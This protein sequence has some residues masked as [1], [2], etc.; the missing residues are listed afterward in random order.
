MS[1]A[2]RRTRILGPERLLDVPYCFL[3]RD[4]GSVTRL[5]EI[6]M[7]DVPLVSVRLM[8]LAASTGLHICVSLRLPEQGVGSRPVG[9]QTFVETD[10][11]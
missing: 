9:I 3:D 11:H 8:R 2:C 1:S 4:L 10:G 5:L 6:R 7:D